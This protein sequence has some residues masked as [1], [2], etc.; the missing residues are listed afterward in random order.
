MNLLKIICVFS[1]LFFSS[2]LFA[3]KEVYQRITDFGE[4]ISSLKFGFKQAIFSEDATKYSKGIIFYQ[5]REKFK[6][7]YASGIEYISDSESLWI[8]DKKKKQALKKSL[9]KFFGKEIIQFFKFGE[10][11]KKYLIDYWQDKEKYYF[12]FKRDTQDI[13]V[14]IN[15]KTLMPNKIIFNKGDLR[16]EIKIFKIKRNLK[17]VDEFFLFNP[18]KNMEVMEF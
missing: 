1:F 12:K 6:I 13:L 2:S 10:D 5:A 15:K 18:S 14:F 17:L 16:F 8:V 7:V 4:N 11:L 3:N 9:N